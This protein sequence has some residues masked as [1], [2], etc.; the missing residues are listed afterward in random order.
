M[1]KHNCQ[2]QK[3]RRN[4]KKKRE[5]DKDKDK[6]GIST[7]ISQ[8]HDRPENQQKLYQKKKKIMNVSN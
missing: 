8:G 5:K 6:E 7:R 4:D 3:K 2:K 1:A